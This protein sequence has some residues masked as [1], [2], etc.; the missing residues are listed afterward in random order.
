MKKFKSLTA[1]I[2]LIA[3]KSWATTYYVTP[4]GSN[5][6]NGLAATTGG[7]N[8]PWA[9]LTYAASAGVLAAGDIVY[10][11]AGN[12]GSENVVFTKS[13]TSGS[14][15]S[16]I[17]YTSTPGDTPPVLV[18]SAT[19]STT[20]ST[21]DMPTYT[22]WSR[23]SAGTG[24]DLSAQKY[25]ILKNF[26]IRTYQ[27]GV[28]AGGTAAQNADYITLENVNVMTIGSTSVAYS[29]KAIQLGSMGTAFSDHSTLKNCLVINSTYSG[30]D[31][32]GDY[33]TVTGCKVF[34]N[35][36]ITSLA[37][38]D[39]YTTVCG[40]YNTF[41][42][43]YV[44][45]ASGLTN[46]G[47]GIG[48]WSNAEQ[49][50]DQGLPLGAIA[51]QYNTFSYCSAKNMGE[52]FFVHNRTAQYNTF[53]HCDAIGTHT[54]T[55]A[56][57]GEGEGIVI[58]DG[59]SDNV[60]DGCK[61]ADCSAGITF[62]DTSAD[63]DTGGSPTGHPGNNN[64]IINTQINNCYIGVYYSD[65]G[66][67]SDA[68]DNTIAN[69]TFYKSRY[70]HYAGRHCTKIKYLGNIYFGTSQNPYGGYF[71][72]NTYSSDIVVN[73]TYTY[74]KQ[75]D[76][77]YIEGG[78]P[79]GFVG[80]NGNISS[81]PLF[82]STSNLHLT[83]T[84]PCIDKVDQVSLSYNPKDYDGKPRYFGAKSDIGAYEGYTGNVYYVTT[85]GSNSN[86]GLAETT[87][88]GNGPWATLTYAASSTPNLQ[89]GD[90]V[91][92]KAGSYGNENV[93]FANSG[94]SG[95]PISYIGYTSTP[96]DAPPVLVTTATGSTTFSTS[97]MPTYT[98][99]SRSSGIAFDARPRSY[100]TLKNFQIRT[101]EY[102]FLG[103]GT[104]AQNAGNLVLENVNAMTLG[105]TSSSYSGK[106]LQVGDM[107]TKFS[108][109]N[110]LTN[111]LVINAGAEAFDI[112]GNY[113]TLTGCKAF[114]SENTGNAATDYYILICGTKNTITSCYAERQAGISHGGH[115]IGAKTNAEQVIDQG[116][117]LDTIPADSNSFINC[118]AKNIAESF[119][120]RHRLAKYN[121][122]DHCSAIGTHTGTSDDDGEGG[123][124]TIRDGASYNT[125][126]GCT[127]T[128]CATGITFE[129]TV[130]DGDT[131]GSPTGHPGN[132]NF[133]LNGIIKNC[134]IGVE[135]SD[136]SIQSDAGNNTIGNCT[137]YKTRYLHYAARHC[138]NMKYIG[139]IYYGTSADPH[140][141][142]FK[143]NTYAS[144][145]VPNGT[146]TYFKQ[147][148][149][150]NIEGFSGGTLTSYT[151]VNSNI[152]ADPLFVS[153]SNLHLTSSSPCI[154]IVDALTNAVDF[155]NLARP[156][157][158]KA[159]IGAYEYYAGGRINNQDENVTI[160]NDQ[161]ITL[162]PNPS[163]G[164]IHINSG[165][166]ASYQI[167]IFN[168]M[169]QS[170]YKKAYSNTVDL[171]EL[172]SGIYFFQI[173]SSN[174]ELVADKKISIQQ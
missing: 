134:Y 64:K 118:S 96:G 51:A 92:V 54:G 139:N 119:F 142:Y 161:A 124:I 138:A 125:F 78:N 49:V 166:D 46:T 11:K 2:C 110:T 60:F 158:S 153:S 67:Q 41:T 147:C 173:L 174:G 145:I 115:G 62:E 157:G 70:L 137:F 14:P 42:S 21:S 133:V 76:F 39:F 128:D 107:G 132:Y 20:F 61:I 29:G 15:I 91:Y 18:S 74:F 84:S 36:N 10:V 169:G 82:V 58:R 8:G 167:H 38:T 112:N 164:L 89:P 160:E 57:S 6:N 65:Y 165:L 163:T 90:V 111:C 12:Y 135:Y 172:N 63:G 69:C 143:G 103:G 16:F 37:S 26:Q 154:N 97:D 113:N 27:I 86:N 117:A 19:A 151:S 3:V 102:A 127:I 87:G 50:V 162:Y 171:S 146:Y 5:S 71:K 88:G 77:I 120:V 159:E 31:I 100:I 34:C 122:F 13:G 83:N 105:N 116:L 152:S 75:C 129:D 136:Y 59:A 22:G 66:V 156:N 48:A 126:N 44:E 32:N 35:E 170:V 4:S 85:S 68:G 81:D 95:N 123:G 144:D 121:Y 109:R 108:N 149:F 131:G 130:E 9:T 55:S 150:Y 148:D 79:S 40:S 98:G 7:G 155:D 53:Y 45:R 80:T 73:G 23:S 28:L 94:T 168:V 56:S 72:G 106:G 141:G 24:F 101:Y 104:K 1:L 52:S 140:G 25:I 30:I 99:S 43:C 93:V 114:C 47:T 33:N 17:G